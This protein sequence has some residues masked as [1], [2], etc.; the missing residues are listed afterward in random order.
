MK[1]LRSVA[2]LVLAVMLALSGCGPSSCSRDDGGD[3]TGGQTEAIIALEP[4]ESVEFDYA[5]RT[6]TAELVRVT[7]TSAEIVISS[8]PT[9][10]V[11]TEGASAEADLDADSLPDAVLMVSDVTEDGASLTVTA[12]GNPAYDETG[13]ETTGGLG[14]YNITGYYEQ[15]PAMVVLDDGS[16]LLFYTGG[17]ERTVQ[18]ER[19]RPDG[20]QIL[21]PQLGAGRVDPVPGIARGEFL[22][23]VRTEDRIFMASEI[24]RGTCITTYDLEMQDPSVASFIT[25]WEK[26]AA[27]AT[28]GERVWLATQT[29]AAAT[30]PT[31]G[32]RPA[33]QVI[34]LGGGKTPVR[35]T[36]GTV[37]DPPDGKSD[38]APTM[39]YDPDSGML[40]VPYERTTSA[41]GDCELRCAIVDPDTLEATDDV[42]IVGADEYSGGSEHGVAS[43]ASG[44]VV[45]VFWQTGGKVNQHISTVDCATGQVERTFDGD[46]ENDIPTLTANNWDVEL[47]ELETGPALLYLNPDAHEVSPNAPDADRFRY[48]LAPITAEGPAG[49]PT[50]LEGGQPI[51]A[52][53][54]FDLASFRTNP[55]KAVCGS[56][57]LLN[58]TVINRGSR[59]ANGVVLDATID[60]KSIGTLEFESLKPGEAV[61]FAKVWDVPPHL[62]AEEVEVGYSLTCADE[63][64]TTGNDSATTNVRIIQKG[65]VQGRVS[66]ASMAADLSW[67]AGGLEGVTVSFGGK[68]VLTDASGAFVIEDVEFGSGTLTA[69]KEGFNPASAEVETTR[70][71]PI[72]S[73]GVRMDNHGTLV[74]HVTDEAGVALSGVD[75]YLVGYDRSE[76]TDANGDLTLEVPFGTYSIAFR[77]SGYQGLAP[78]E[79]EVRLGEQTRATVVLKEATSGQLTGR[80]ID[81]LGTGV[82]GASVTIANSKGEAVSTL[83]TDA[84]GHFDA[85]ELPVKP[86]GNYS[87][88]ASATGLTVTEPVALSGGEVASV[89]IELVPDRGELAQRDA[90]EGYTSWMIKAAWPGFLDVGGQSIYVWYG[91][92]AVRVGAQYWDGDRDLNRVQVT[93]W[94]GKYETHATKGEIEFPVSGDDLTGNTGKKLPPPMGQVTDAA[95]QSWWKST[96]KSALSLYKEYSPA[97]TLA[98]TIYSGIQ[99]V[100]EAFS[101][102]DQWLILGQGAEILTWKESLDDFTVADEW[103]WNHPLDSAKSLKEAIPTSFA[104]PIVIGGA[105]VQETAVRVDGIDV[106]DKET[107]EVY[108][109]DRAQW[110]SY[111]DDAAANSSIRTFDIDRMGVPVDNVRI[112]VWVKVQKYWNDAPGG[113]C[114]DQREQQVVIMDPDTG[115]QKAFIAPGDMY[116]DPGRWTTEDIARLASD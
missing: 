75:T 26:D 37:T 4:G 48:V 1:R 32:P 82:A 79:F 111:S 94:G 116:L 70:T 20:T 87:I 40:A 91:N 51:L 42:L 60:G 109:T 96:A 89:M 95:S 78:Q 65:V 105:S 107:G 97:I 29:A 21:A 7:G 17:D 84:E 27:L 110:F 8:S 68:T 49:D 101:D 102:E 10:Y 92:Y 30:R 63:Q 24:S 74:V 11:L 71:K 85:G 46:S 80:V 81:R 34:E 115:G 67:W 19:Y 73:V 114:F 64:Y 5:G 88:T 31:G 47:I 100:R 41:T 15:D 44:G 61:V 35:L 39:S 33:V 66:N 16:Y 14:P 28:D 50:I 56:P 12:L 103:D 3:S 104:I 62:T 57:C 2:L 9:T 93:T 45:L 72:A 99:D 83:T 22:S 6:H 43:L 13:F 106:V 59:N 76:N 69:T 36:S 54:T 90:T 53:V 25:P 113:T 23:V 86:S 98:K 108:Y 112:Y 55:K 58:G 77:K 38:V 18:W 52:D